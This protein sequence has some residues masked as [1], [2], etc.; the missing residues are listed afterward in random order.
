MPRYLSP[1]WF[2]AAGAVRAE[3]PPGVDIA[4]EQVVLA[5]GAD[6]RYCVHIQNESVRIDAGPCPRA[7]ATFTVEYP[8][9]AAL[10]RGELTPEAALME[11]R[12][13]VAGDIGTL[14]ANQAA[15]TGL[16]SLGAAFQQL[17]TETTF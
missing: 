1:A 11:G 14:L 4:L 3:A 5:D 17:R 8:T 10:F 6:V 2:A 13:K 12:M 15:L 7:D 9:S 16:T